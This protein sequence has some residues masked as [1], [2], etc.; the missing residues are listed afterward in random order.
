MP[1]HAE[2]LGDIADCGALDLRASVVPAYAQ[3]WAVRMVVR[4]VAIAGF[5]GE[6]NPAYEG[7][8]I[9][10]HDRLFVVAVERSFL[11]VEAALNF[12]VSDELVTDLPYVASRGTK[13]R[14]RRSGPDEYAHVQALGELLEQVVK[15]DLLTVAYECE[16]R[17]EVPACQVD[18][19]AGSLQLR[20]DDRQ[21]MRAVDQDVD[22]IARSRRGVSGRPT[23]DG[24]VECVCTSDPPQTTPMMSAD[25]PADLVS[26]PTLGQE[27]RFTR[28]RSQPIEAGT[29]RRGSAQ[30]RR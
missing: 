16:V 22:R 4:V 20:R 15:H 27:Q 13:E 25:Q 21:S 18:M 3:I 26:E 12:C 19:R 17:C 8:A 14:Q 6:I 7:D 23:A 28:R 5:R 29:S 10:D 11:R 2:V 24:R 30:I 9:V 1:P